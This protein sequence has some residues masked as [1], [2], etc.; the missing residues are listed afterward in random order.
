MRFHILLPALASFLFS[1]PSLSSPSDVL[2]IEKLT[3][4]FAINLD[5]KNF[6]AFEVEFIPTAT[7]DPGNG[8]VK[9]VPAI[10]KA[11]AA[12]V[13]NNVTQSS[14][15]TQSI[16]LAPP[17]DVQ[18]AAGKAS[19]ITYAIVS[20]IGQDD[21][22][23]KVFI[24]YGLFKDKLVKTGDFGNYGG[25]KF[26][27]RAFV[28]LVSAQCCVVAAKAMEYW[29]NVQRSTLNLTNYQSGHGWRHLCSTCNRAKRLKP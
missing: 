3:A 22:A 11:L 21:D 2:Y 24:F 6:K 7:Y 4:D 26:S 5:L 15:T 25:W 19:A 10:Q 8:A 20:Y 16:N 9:G 12:V 27:E 28:T 23:G 18:G 13:G 17:F 1:T 29:F 14:L